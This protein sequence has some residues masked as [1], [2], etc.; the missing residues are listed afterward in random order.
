M[1]TEG[2][3]RVNRIE[4]AIASH[5]QLCA[6]PSLAKVGVEGSN[7]FD[8]FNFLQVN[9]TPR[10]V[11]RDLLLLPRLWHDSWGSRGRSRPKRN[12]AG[13]LPPSANIAS[14]NTQFC[15]QNLRQSER[16]CRTAKALCR[17][18]ASLE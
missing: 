18:H 4:P 8:R 14:P 10:R 17:C 12:A 3:T 7:P 15:L 11:L 9:Q 16:P 2:L 13:S 6:I 5:K 1:R